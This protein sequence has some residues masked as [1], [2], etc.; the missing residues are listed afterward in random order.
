MWTPALG[1]DDAKLRNPIASPV[2]TTTYILRV[3]NSVGCDDFDTITVT[4]NEPTVIVVPNL[5]TPNGDGA[6]DVWDLRTVPGIDD[7]KVTVFNRWGKEVYSS[8]KYDHTWD[9]TYEGNPLPE[10]TYV[11][12]IEYLKGG[13]EIVKGNLQIIR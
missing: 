5:F 12:I 1:L 7:S 11:Y 13:L 4:V 9:G 2:N 10:G 6:N 8:L 3:F